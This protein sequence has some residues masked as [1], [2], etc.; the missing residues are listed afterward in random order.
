MN[1]VS[2][3]FCSFGPPIFSYSDT[4]SSIT[5]VFSACPVSYLLAIGHISE[6]YVPLENTY[7]YWF[8]YKYFTRPYMVS[9]AHVPVSFLVRKTWSILYPLARGIIAEQ[10]IISVVL[11]IVSLDFLS[12]ICHCSISYSGDTVE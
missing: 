7:E 3:M 11:K 2:G 12:P 8:L 6:K 5:N 1:S 10:V 4:L 9:A